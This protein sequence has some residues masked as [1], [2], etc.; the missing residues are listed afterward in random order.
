M[1]KSLSSAGTQAK[2]DNTGKC[3]QLLREDQ[4]ILVC[5]SLQACISMMITLWDETSKLV[6]RKDEKLMGFYESWTTV[7]DSTSLWLHSNISGNISYHDH[8]PEINCWSDPENSAA[9]SQVS[10]CTTSFFKLKYSWY[11][12]RVSFRCIAQLFSY[13]FF[14]LFSLICYYKILNII[15][16]VILLYLVLICFMYSSVY[17][18]ILNS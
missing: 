10:S 5:P 18:F 6:R 7:A 17:M 13:N 8:A 4:V 12:M 16:C 2:T 1:F 9:H 14:R 11:T 3:T 15:P